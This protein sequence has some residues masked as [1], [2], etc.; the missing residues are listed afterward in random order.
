MCRSITTLRGLDPAATDEEIA[1]AALQYVRKIS[2]IRTPTGPTQVA[3]DDAVRQVAA[4][5]ASLLSDLPARKVA[6][7]T[8]PPRRRLAASR[9]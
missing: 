2:G 5:T 6:P 7:P 8:V 1:D 4:A 9:H 3:F